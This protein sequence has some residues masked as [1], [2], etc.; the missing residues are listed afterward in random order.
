LNKDGQ[1]DGPTNRQRD[2]RIDG[3]TRA[4]FTDRLKE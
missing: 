1:T 4:T 3:K 2:V